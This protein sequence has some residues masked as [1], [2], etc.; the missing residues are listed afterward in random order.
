MSIIYPGRFQPP[1]YGHIKKIYLIKETFE[2]EPKLLILV[3]KRKDFY[4][5]LSEEEVLDLIKSYK[6]NFN[7][8][9]L[10]SPFEILK[11]VKK[12]DLLI[13]GSY[14]K[15]LIYKLLN[16]NSIYIPREKIKKKEVSSTYIKKLV[17]DNK[18]EEA[19]NYVNHKTLYK[20]LEK[21]ES[22]IL[23]KNFS[24]KEKFIKKLFYKY[25]FI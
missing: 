6:I 7:Y 3:S 11:K 24:D 15:H 23:L 22:S 19:L 8:D 25:N 20:L 18:I 9:F 1:H 4:N 16:K 21:K 12:Y 2:E 14:K 17:I 5:P 10:Y 13:T